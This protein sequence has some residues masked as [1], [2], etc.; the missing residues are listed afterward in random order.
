MP[1]L[2]LSDLSNITGNEQ[3]AITTINNNN[4]AIE[5]A[6]ENTL[7]RDGTSPNSMGA[8]LDMNSNDILNVTSIETGTLEATSIEAS[9]YTQDGL[10]LTSL[11]LD[12]E[13]QW[14]ISES[15]VIGDVVFNLG[16]SYVCI[17]VHTSDATNQPGQ[18][19]LWETY[20]DLIVQGGTAGIDSGGVSTDNAV[21]RWDG[22]VGTA[23]QNSGVIIDDSNNVTGVGTLA[24]GTHTITGNLVVSGTVDGRDISTDGTKLDTIETGAEVNDTAA[25]IL[26]KLLTVDGPGSGLNADLLDNL[27]SADYYQVGGTDVT[28]A[29]GGTGRSSATAY[30]V[31]CGGTTATGILQSIASVGSLG[32]VLTSNGASA[33][34]TFETPGS[35]ITEV[36]VQVF[37][38]SGTYTPTAGMAYCLVI[39]TGAGGGG[40]GAD[41]SDTS[42]TRAGG[43]GGGGA[44]CIELF[45][46]ATIGASQS[47]TIGTGG[48]GGANTGGN[49][50][51]G[52]DT[53]FGALH[54][55]GG[56]VGATGGVGASSTAILAGGAGGTASGGLLNI[57]GG[58]GGYST[59][60]SSRDSSGSAISGSGGG[61]FWGAGPGSIN[62]F[63]SLAGIAGGAYGT[64]GT[65]GTATDTTTGVTGGTGADGVCFVLEFVN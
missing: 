65:G 26:T 45:S 9:S 30:A 46:A 4:S 58:M 20:W 27:S 48:A 60:I 50:G 52:G 16:S 49:G 13:G 36:A 54:T 43:G 6:L 39:S 38:A 14:L 41:N 5:T 34:P 33:L 64:G 44:T 28:V 31:I 35:G 24:S 18:G 3:S 59:S 25:E 19:A 53:T 32:Q 55:A 61:T 21:V 62:S 63:T 29:D 17:V 2:T 37:T 11:L 47:V 22:L 8:D 15:Y 56:G 7:S 12:W 42:A 1:K 57:A 40:G 10:N 51:N 23:V